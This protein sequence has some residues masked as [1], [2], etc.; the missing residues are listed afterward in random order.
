MLQI[1]QIRKA[2]I[3]EDSFLTP[4]DVNPVF[5]YNK[6]DSDKNNV[7]FHDFGLDLGERGF[8]EGV[9]YYLR[10]SVRRYPVDPQE[11]QQYGEPD[12]VNFNLMLCRNQGDPTSGEHG[13]TER[14]QTLEKNLIITPYQDGVN[15]P[16]Q[17]FTLVFT[18]TESARYLWFKVNRIGYDYIYAAEDDPSVMGRAV[19]RYTVAEA[20]T[21]TIEFSDI[22]NKKILVE[23]PI[24]ARDIYFDRVSKALEAAEIPDKDLI[25]D[26]M[27]QALK[28]RKNPSIEDI[29][30]FWKGEKIYEEQDIKVTGEFSRIENILHQSNVVQIGIQSRPGA[31]FVVNHEPIYLGRSG[32]YEVNNGTK[33]T[34]IGVVAPNGS[35]KDNIQEF[36]LDYAYTEEG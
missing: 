30:L 19:F 23:V 3:G 14:L 31:L 17:Q 15:T 33:I 13:P 16:W 27:E 21:N 29:G 8:K 5:I 4:L 36:I 2:S 32:I 10:F 12:R 28:D 25:L 24:V 22:E 7:V 6:G 35:E 9:S 34:S 11:E 18:P 26:I 1:G 20:A